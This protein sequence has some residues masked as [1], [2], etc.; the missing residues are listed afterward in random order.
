VLLLAGTLAFFSLPAQA[1]NTEALARMKKDITFLASDLC[2]GRGV[3]TKGI[4]LA[5]DYIAGE[6]QKAGLKPAG[7]DGSYFQPF[8]MSSASTLGSPN[9]LVLE[10]PNGRKIELRHGDDFQ[11][12]GLSASGKAAAPLVFAGYAITA[13]E[14]GY[15]D[16]RGIDAAGKILIVIRKAPQPRNKGESS[17]AKDKENRIPWTVREAPLSSKMDRAEEHHA[18]GVVFVNDQEAA[19]SDRLM[20]FG[21][22]S[23]GSAA[24]IPAVQIH[25]SQADE[26]LKAALGKSLLELEGQIDRDLKPQSAAMT[27]W[28]ANIDVHV[29][30]AVTHVKNVVGVLE[31]AG[32]LANETVIVGAHYDHLG[33][34][35]IGSLA[36]DPAAKAIHH[37]AD[38]NASGTTTIMELARRFSQK[39]DRQGRRLVFIAFSGE[40]MGLLGSQHYCKKPIFP[41]DQTAAMVNLDMVGRLRPDK[42]KKKDK[43]IVYGTKTSPGFDQLI[44]TLNAPFDFY[45]KKIPSGNGPSDQMSFYAKGVPVFFFFT[46]DHPDYH[47]PTDTADKINLAGMERVAELVE[48]VIEHLRTVPE[49][50][51]FTKVADSTTGD[52]RMQGP[53]LGI[54]PMY[55]DDKEGVLLNGVTEGG[56]AEKAGLKEGDRIMEIDGKAVKNLENYM[57][58]M[59]GH[60]KGETLELGITRDGK[61]MTVK[62]KL[63]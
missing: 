34:G 63:E 15:D 49:R 26:L 5:A 48:G 60:K 14:V 38:D 6:F 42:E 50:P 23:F 3:T 44:E 43:L 62:V 59:G 47:R 39:P 13:N 41:L 40:E 31:G 22:T 51:R 9:T 27:G 25:R 55:G 30:R 45:L 37:G 61:T 7:E 52:R 10:G 19:T 1:E 16:F 58:L 29:G 54:R 35:G 18:A 12:M 53:R 20:D 33:Y 21:Y 2:E 11:V 24:K 28:S 56:A 4:N 32:P 57:V 17:P 8:T 46:D 36:R